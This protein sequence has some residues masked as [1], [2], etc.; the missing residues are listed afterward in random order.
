MNQTTTINLLAAVAFFFV[1]LTLGCAWF[2]TR[3]PAPSRWRF[4][5]YASL[6]AAMVMMCSMIAV[7]IN[8]LSAEKPMLD[9][10]FSDAAMM[11]IAAGGMGYILFVLRGVDRAMYGVAEVVFA[12]LSAGIVGWQASEDNFARYVAIAAAIYVVVRGLDNIQTGRTADEPT[13]FA[14]WL[15]KVLPK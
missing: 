13:I 8:G 15:N 12:L 1:F 10:I 3:R 11:V 6:F 14:H 7:S 5:L 2:M 9:R 4:G